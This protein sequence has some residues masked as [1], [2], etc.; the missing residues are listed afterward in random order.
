MH[1][2]LIPH[3]IAGAAVTWD[4]GLGECHAYIVMLL[5]CESCHV[6]LSMTL[7]RWHVCV[8]VCATCHFTVTHAESC[9]LQ[10]I[11]EGR[12]T[13]SYVQTRPQNSGIAAHC[14]E[15]ILCHFDIFMLHDIYATG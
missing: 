14:L 5:A 10:C 12:K 6:M 1:E 13:C 15:H 4:T 3:N 11:A 9:L 2:A 7:N 8:C